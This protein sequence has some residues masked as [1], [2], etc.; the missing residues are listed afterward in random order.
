MSEYK[1]YSGNKALLS[2]WIRKSKIKQ[3]Y[4][5]NEVGFFISGDEKLFTLSA[6]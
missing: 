5:S 6:I 3:N 2:N 4:G 1:N